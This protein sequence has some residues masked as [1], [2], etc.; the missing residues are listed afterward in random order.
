MRI[1][2]GR[3]VPN[4]I[5]QALSGKP[6]TVYG[7]G[8][9]TR[10]F[11][12]IKDLID[13]IWKLMNSNLYEPVNLGNPN[14]FTILE[15]AELILRLTNSKSA[16]TYCPLPV[17]DPKVRCPDI[18]FARQ[19]LSWEPKIPLEEGLKTT[20]QYFLSKSKNPNS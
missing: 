10:S 17:N 3:V 2:D 7:D 13:G 8:K 18:T 11:C 4:F 19:K 6:L 5:I 12:Y 1:N 15:F 16:I 14:E 20:I 9:Q